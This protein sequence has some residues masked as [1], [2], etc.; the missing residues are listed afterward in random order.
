MKKKYIEKD[1]NLQKK[2]S[3]LLMNIQ[4]HNKRISKNNKILSIIHQINPF[5]FRTKKWVETN[6]ESRATYNIS[7]QIKF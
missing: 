6:D 1:I 7:N 3:K 5:K 4:K 2:D